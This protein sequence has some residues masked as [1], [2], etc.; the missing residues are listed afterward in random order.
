MQIGITYIPWEIAKG[1]VLA[2]SDDLGPGDLYARF[3]DKGY[4]IT[5]TREEVIARMPTPEEARGLMLPEGVPV[6]VVF[7]PA[8]TKT[9]DP[10][11]SPSS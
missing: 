1:S 2:R 11:R 8:S 5:F 9:D 6:L 10:S 3:E 7:I 4:S